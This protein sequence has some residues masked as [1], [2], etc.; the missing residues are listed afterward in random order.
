[1]Q[2]SITLIQPRH[3]YAPDNWL[4][5]I[6]MPN[7]LLTLGA[8]LQKADYE[9]RICD[10]NLEKA[11][12]DTP[13]VGITLTGTPYIPQ[14]QKLVARIR[15][16]YGDQIRIILGGQVLAPG[17][18]IRHPKAPGWSYNTGIT[19]DQFYK[20]FGSWVYNGMIVQSLLVPAKDVALKDM[21]QSLWDAKLCA[22]MRNEMPLYVSQ[23]CA[24]KCS[25]CAA[26]KGVPE[27][28]RELNHVQTDLTYLLGKATDYYIDNLSFYMTNLDVF[29]SPK[30][31]FAFAKMV[32]SVR[33]QYPDITVNIRWL[34]W[35]AYFNKAYHYQENCEYLVEELKK[36]WFTTVWFGVD[37]VGPEIWKWT[38]KAQN[39]EKIVLEAFQNTKAAWLI[40]ET[41]MVMGHNG[42]DTPKSL[43]EAL[44]FTQWAQQE[45]GA[46]PRPQAVKPYIPWNDW[47]NHPDYVRPIEQMIAKSDL[48][49]ALDFTAL[50]SFM[51][52][53]D[54]DFR[55]LV[56]DYLIKMTQIPGNTTKLVEPYEY[57]DTPKEK[58]I[59]R[60]QNLLKYDR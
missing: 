57:L 25:F 39:S 14:V 22:Y 40:P 49:Q 30:K 58:E 17:K 28:Y 10:E 46:V 7:S 38:K 20:L 53:P 56:R 34:A 2:K 3:S 21:Y 42:I 32:Q 23:W 4:G 1:M 60:Y 36:A 29:Q 35:C 54:R 15:Q 47:R 18:N 27:E 59:K 19:S 43:E 55:Q 16:D 45:F 13:S 26:A 52:H 44:Q 11:Q 5:H 8:Q 31:L 24:Q 41:L 50:P 12:I 33:K 51:T 48:F 9:V 6:Y 37:G